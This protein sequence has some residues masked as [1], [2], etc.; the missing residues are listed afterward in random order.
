MAPLEVIIASDG[1]HWLWEASGMHP[2]PQIAVRDLRIVGLLV[3][4][5]RAPG[6]HGPLEPCGR[7]AFPLVFLSTNYQGADLT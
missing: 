6:P 5:L 1:G 7:L 4:G 3:L 2:G